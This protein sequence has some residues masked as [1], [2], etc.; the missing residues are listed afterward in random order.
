MVI[1]YPS[2]LNIHFEAGISHGVTR[3][4]LPILVV[5]VAHVHVA[6]P[7]PGRDGSTFVPLRHMLSYE[8]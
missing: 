5:A 7:G 4:T 8:K 6:D 2:I 1:S 3:L